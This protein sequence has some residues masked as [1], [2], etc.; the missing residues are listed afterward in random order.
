MF[1]DFD[2]ITNK[3]F[4][5]DIYDDRNKLLLSGKIPTQFEIISLNPTIRL[6]Q[7][8]E[9]KDIKSSD[10][11]Y[12]PVFEYEFQNRGK[13]FIINIKKIYKCSITKH[14]QDSLLKIVQSVIDLKKN[15]SIL[16]NNYTLLFLAAISGNNSCLDRVEYLNNNQ[17]FD[18]S[19]GELQS[20]IKYLTEIYK[21]TKNN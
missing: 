16:E 1:L 20:E 15:V 7:S 19:L 11:S 18:G 8:I 17:D 9:F 5:F 12:K 10:W 3:T 14:Q 2:S 6:I 4:E 21:N 13:S